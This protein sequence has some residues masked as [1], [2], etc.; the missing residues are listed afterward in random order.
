V[1]ISQGCDIDDPRHQ[2]ARAQVPVVV[3]L[4]PAGE[5]KGRRTAHEG[6]SGGRRRVAITSARDHRRRNSNKA[7]TGH[8]DVSGP[9]MLLATKEVK[10]SMQAP[11]A[12]HGMPSAVALAVQ[13]ARGIV[14]SAGCADC[15]PCCH[16]FPVAHAGARTTN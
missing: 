7:G 14:A 13:P 12:C 11:R 5:K 15:R 8:G 6:V 16:S 3:E 2:V 10:F 4:L 9:R 1:P